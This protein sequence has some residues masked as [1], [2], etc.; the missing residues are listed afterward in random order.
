MGGSCCAAEKDKDSCPMMKQKDA[1]TS[2]SIDMT[3]V[4]VVGDAS[5]ESCCQPGADCCAKGG[6]C[7]HKK[8]S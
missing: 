5:G 7:C 3:N 2:A 1:Q 4:T 6:S 8:K